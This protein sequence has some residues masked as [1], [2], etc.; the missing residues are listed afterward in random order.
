MSRLNGPGRVAGRIMKNAVVRLAGLLFAAAACAAGAQEYPTRPVTVVMPFVAGGVVDVA[1]R[2]VLEDVAT[3]WPQPIIIDNKPGAEGLIG[4][5]LAKRASADGYTL[6]GAAQYI[7]TSPLLRTNPGYALSDFTPV[8]IIGGGPNVIVTSPSLP[9]KTLKE[10]VDYA[11]ARPGQLNA[12][13]GSRGGSVHLGTETFMQATGIQMQTVP[14]KGAPDMIPSLVSGQL[15]FALLPASVAVPV[16]KAGKVKPLAVAAPVRVA[17]LPEVPTVVEAGFP[18]DSVVFPWYGIMARAGTPAAVVARWNA[19][20]NTALHSP[21]VIERL[22]GMG[23]V[24]T[25]HTIGEFDEML[26]QEQARWTKLFR[27]RDIRPE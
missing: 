23:V 22:K 3:R 1:T 7:V 13:T 24:A 25:A 26:K 5:Q 17:L 11:R 16:I 15:A 10:F 2:V 19:E 18:A 12:A 14:F 4:T 8:A 21:K 9:V 27:E 6:L 20:I